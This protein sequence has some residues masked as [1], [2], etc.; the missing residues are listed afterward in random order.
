VLD[1][2]VCDCECL[3]RESMF[4]LIAIISLLPVPT[5]WDI[6]YQL[7]QIRTP[8]VRDKGRVSDDEAQPTDVDG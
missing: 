7:F 2:I 1:K 5:L 6:V 4:Y 8:I 3:Y